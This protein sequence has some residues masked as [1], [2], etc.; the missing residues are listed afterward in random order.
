ML[1]TLKVNIMNK[2]ELFIW[3]YTA[4]GQ[5]LKLL[6]LYEDYWLSD[7]YCP[8]KQVPILGDWVMYY[9]PKDGFPTYDVRFTMPETLYLHI[10]SKIQPSFDWFPQ[11]YKLKIVSES[12]LGFMISNQ[13]HDRFETTECKVFGIDGKEFVAKKYFVIRICEFD[14]DKFDFHI[15]NKKRAIGCNKYNYFL[16]PDMQLKNYNGR[17]NIFFLDEFCYQNGIILTA[18]GKDYV[19]QNFNLPELY[20]LEDYRFVW[21]N[22]YNVGQ[23]PEMIK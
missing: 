23:L 6:P 20:K 14:D 22:R 9:P 15:E 5:E 2:Q 7:K 12:F 4:R 11:N 19:M 16:Y 10:K 3:F 8:K 13:L 1:F 17:Q 21:N 18:D